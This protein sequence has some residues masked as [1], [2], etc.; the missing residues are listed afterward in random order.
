[1]FLAVKIGKVSHKAL[2][3]RDNICVSLIPPISDNFNCKKHFYLIFSTAPSRML[4]SILFAVGS[5]AVVPRDTRETGWWSS[6]S[7][8]LAAHTN[9]NTATLTIRNMAAAKND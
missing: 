7:P 8:G 2:S 1:M 6:L 5:L 3:I 4:S 9:T